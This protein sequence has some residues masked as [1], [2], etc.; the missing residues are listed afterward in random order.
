MSLSFRE[1]QLECA[2]VPLSLKWLRLKLLKWLRDLFL[3]IIIPAGARLTQWR[4]QSRQVCR[5]RTDIFLALYK[6]S[7][8]VQREVN[9]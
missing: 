1:L 6:S 5:L 3:T 8:A 2:A 4:R 9:A 7:T